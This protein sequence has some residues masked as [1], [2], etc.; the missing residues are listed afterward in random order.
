MFHQIIWDWMDVNLDRLDIWSMMTTLTNNVNAGPNIIQ[1][2]SQQTWLWNKIVRAK[3]NNSDLKGFPNLDADPYFV[4]TLR[5]NWDWSNHHPEMSSSLLTRFLDQRC[6]NN[7]MLT[8]MDAQWSSADPDIVGDGQQDSLWS[9][10]SP[11]DEANDADINPN[12]VMILGRLH[13][14]RPKLH[15]KTG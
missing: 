7:L 1:R 10:Y 3:N 12:V 8:R 11:F 14:C 9:E 5:Q 6:G 13:W 15:L 4:L 2:L